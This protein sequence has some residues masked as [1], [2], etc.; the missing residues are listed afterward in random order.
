M[1][2]IRFGDARN[3]ELA[4]WS[5]PCRVTLANR[6]EI[7]P[8]CTG[9]QECAGVWLSLAACCLPPACRPRVSVPGITILSTKK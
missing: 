4:A 9:L 3:P 7:V 6:L 5:G 1:A 2:A 8:V